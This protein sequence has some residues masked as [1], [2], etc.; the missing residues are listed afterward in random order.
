MKLD[1]NNI[2]EYAES[3]VAQVRA[4]DSEMAARLDF[5]ERSVWALEALLRLS[6]D[7]FADPTT[8]EAGKDLTIFL[9][10]MLPRRNISALPRRDMAVCG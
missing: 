1:A 3:L 9:R 8:P 7:K 10:G 5:G 4:G 2:R 6:D